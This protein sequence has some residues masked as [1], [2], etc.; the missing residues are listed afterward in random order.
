MSHEIACMHGSVHTTPTSALA[1]LTRGRWVE[2]CQQARTPPCG[3][4]PRTPTL[5]E[6]SPTRHNQHNAM[7]MG[8]AH[9]TDVCS[10]AEHLNS[11]AHRANREAQVR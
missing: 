5:A 3:C 10:C 2:Y 7:Q 6:D 1:P 9:W 11:M 4:A 8:T